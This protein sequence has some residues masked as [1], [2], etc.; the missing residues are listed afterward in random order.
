MISEIKQE[1]ILEKNVMVPMRD[2]VR[3]A[4][5]IYR[6]ADE[7]PVPVL[8]ARLPYNKDRPA[9]VLAVPLDRFVQA[10]YAVVIQDLRGRYSSEGE[11]TRIRDEAHDGVDTIEWITDQPWSLGPVG[12][13]GASYLGIPQWLAATERPPALQAI[14][15]MHCRHSMYAYQSGAFE[16]GL[17]L[18]WA[19]KQGAEG[20][21]HHRL[22]QEHT[23]EEAAVL[24]QAEKD[25]LKVF[26]DLPFDHL[27]LT[28]QPLLTQFAPYYF[29]WLAH[30][31]EEAEQRL[32]ARTEIYG[33]ITI[34]S[35]N[36]G[37]WYDMFLDGILENYQQMK[38]QGGS[39]AQ[40]TQH[41]VIGP[42]AH[43]DL[44]GI[45]PERDY[46]PVSSTWGANLVGTHLR[47][48]D[49]WLKGIDNGVDQEKPVKIFVMGADVWREEEDWP[50]PDT[51][52]RRYYLHS[53]GHANSLPEDGLLSSEEPG[54]EAED[55]YT[56]DPRNPVPTIG[57]AN[58]LPME[59]NARVQPNK[60]YFLNAGPRDQRV[61]EER[62]DVLCYTT[63]PL[64]QAVEVTGP[65]ELVLSVSSSALDTDFTGKLVDVYPDSRAEILTDG[66][67]RAR[68]RNSPTDP[69]LLQPEQ[70]YELSIHL[71][72]TSNLFK[73]GH[74]IRLEVSSSNFPRFNRN[75]NTGG[76]IIM[77]RDEDLRQATNKIYHDSIHRSYLVLPIIERE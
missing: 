56:Y 51:S 74:R 19:L 23:E 64:E 16:L 47:W 67:L 20:E 39:K 21:I 33:N 17:W 40:N 32:R 28:D 15:P 72:S 31:A 44:P 55:E 69:T 41:L 73:A 29:D 45:F 49:H 7:K 76:D 24:A 65:I 42:W 13:F 70:I 75:T 71:G 52:Y 62:D 36:I 22:K 54:E 53:Q 11:F 4:T 48:Y 43:F 6:P 30:P 2:G 27:P 3:L 59:K 68:Y 35:L 5:D 66:I 9:E 38:Q 63:A 14:A 60:R 58:L 8:L 46:G 57:G 50:L 18:W 77:E 1:S 10:G 34:P 61:V 12:M 25:L 26:L 37:G